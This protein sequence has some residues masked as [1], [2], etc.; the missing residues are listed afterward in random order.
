MKTE[1]TK[2]TIDAVKTIFITS[3]QIEGNNNKNTNP[4]IDAIPFIF[5]SWH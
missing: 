2:T 4:S 5:G 1:K 3:S